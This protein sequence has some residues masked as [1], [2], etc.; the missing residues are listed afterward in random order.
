MQGTSEVHSDIL[1]ITSAFWNQSEK[2]EM[3][4][5]NMFCEGKSIQSPNWD[6]KGVKEGSKHQ[7]STTH[8][9]KL[10]EARLH[11]TCSSNVHLCWTTEGKF[12]ILPCFGVWI[13]TFFSH[14]NQRQVFNSCK[15]SL[16]MIQQMLGEN[17]LSSVL[18]SASESTNVTLSL[19]TPP[20]NILH[21]QSAVIHLQCPSSPGLLY[22]SQCFSLSLLHMHRTSFLKPS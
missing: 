7:F 11:S 1:K 17:K 9:T 12:N 8:H 10:E 19:I 21:K 3:C 20:K 22:M 5:L 2:T 15:M 6:W 18:L 13:N 14:W 4:L 16:W